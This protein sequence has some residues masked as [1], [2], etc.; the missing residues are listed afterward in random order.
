M[1]GEGIDSLI[2]WMKECSAVGGTPIIRTRGKDRLFRDRVIVA[3]KGSSGVVEGGTIKGLTSSQVRAIRKVQETPNEK[4]NV[5]KL[6]EIAKSSKTGIER[7][8][9]I[10]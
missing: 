4:I 6:K 8:R 3:C 5:S 9:S 2:N 7:R 10:Y 1:L